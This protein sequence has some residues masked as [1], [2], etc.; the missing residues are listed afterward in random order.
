MVNDCK[1]HV[2]NCTQCL[3]LR[4]GKK[5]T[6]APKQII[7]KGAK[8]RYVVDGWKLNDELANISG[9]KW[10]IDIIDHFSKFMGSYS[11]E[12]N[13]P[14]NT[15]ICIKEFCYYVGCPHII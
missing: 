15:L 6:L 8:D 14:V 13:N 4:G 2:A 7:T 1:K 11:I 12:E 10:A 9:Y 3:L 5:F